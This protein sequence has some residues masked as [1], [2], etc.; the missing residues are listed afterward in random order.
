MLH[1]L[2]DQWIL[3]LRETPVVVLDANCEEAALKEKY[4]KLSEMLLSKS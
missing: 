3:H 4:S 1:N 2:H